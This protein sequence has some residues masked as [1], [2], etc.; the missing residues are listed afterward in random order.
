MFLKKKNK[1]EIIA[2]PALIAKSGKAVTP[3][4]VYRFCL[5]VPDLI[6][7]PADNRL[8]LCFLW[9]WVC[10]ESIVLLGAT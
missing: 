10:R 1:K 2:A 8:V 5:F 4:F 6:L 7:T 3:A 9:P